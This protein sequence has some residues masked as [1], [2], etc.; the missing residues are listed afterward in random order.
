MKYFFQLLIICCIPVGALYA[1][2]NQFQIKGTINNMPD[3]EKVMMSYTSA[4]G[5]RLKDTATI[6]DG[7]YSFTG[8]LYEPQDVVLRGLY[9]KEKGKLQ[10]NTNKNKIV[11]YLSPSVITLNSVDSLSNVQIEG[12]PWQKDFLYLKAVMAKR[13]ENVGK[14]GKEMM[15]LEMKKDTAAIEKLKAGANTELGPMMNDVYLKYAQTNHNSPLSLWALQL[16]VNANAFVDMAKVQKAFNAL[17]PYI[18]TLPSAQ[19]VGENIEVAAKI[20]YGSTAPD[21]TLDDVAGKKISLASFKGK[22]VFVDFWA[23]WCTP[24]RQETPYVKK[25]YEKYKAV[26]FEVLSVTSPKESSFEKWTDAIKQDGMNWTNVWDKKGDVSENYKVSGIPANFL[27]DKDGKIVA[28]DLRGM[29][30]EN[31]LKEIF[32]K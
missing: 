16:C 11:L 30:L 24:C 1:Q 2:S 31:K 7:K 23:S 18:K 21:F 22:Y 28:K 15:E 3:V 5:N 27:I 14:F 20:N 32:G 17:D 29:E 13:T 25:A 8:V 4:D 12:A 6:A 10:G 9:S 26:G 19:T